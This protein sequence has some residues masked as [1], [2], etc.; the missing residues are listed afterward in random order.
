MTKKKRDPEEE[1]HLRYLIQNYGEES[2]IGT[3]AKQLLEDKED[4]DGKT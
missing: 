1:K 2:M 3:I 4:T